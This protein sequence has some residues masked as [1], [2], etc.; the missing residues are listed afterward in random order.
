MY[1][2][3]WDI[4]VYGTVLLFLALN[5]WF[6]TRDLFL[7]NLIP[8]A[9]LLVLLAFVSMDR[10]LLLVVFFAPLSLSLKYLAGDMGV[11]LF[12]PTEPLLAGLMILFILKVFLERS[13]SKDIL[14]HPVTAVVILQLVWIAITSLTSSMPLV[15]FKFLVARLWFVAGFYFVAAEMFRDPSAMRKYIWAYILPFT[16]VILY[17]LYRQGQHGLMNQQ[18]SHST[19]H[20]FY[21]DH[22]AYGASMAFL[23]P[24]LAG[25]SF[26]RLKAGYR[27][28]SAAFLSLFLFAMIFS[29][30]R[31]A[32]LSMVVAGL[33]FLVIRLK[34]PVSVLVFSALVLAG[35]LFMYRT[36]IYMRLEENKQASS[37]DF[38]RH[39]KSI[40][41]ITS[42]ASNAER[43]NRWK[44]AWRMFRERP[45]FGW[46]PGT[47]QFKYAAFQMSREKTYIST[48][49]GDRG[50]A[51]SEYLGPL[52]ESGFPGMLIFIALA[53]AGISTGIRVY[54]RAREPGTKYFALSVLLG[55]VTY[56]T[57]GLLNNFLHTDKASA[58]FWGFLAMLVAMDIRLSGRGS[59]ENTAQ[60]NAS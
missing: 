35:F 21:N 7:F 24:V 25:F 58:L 57:H 54:R 9:G 51:H 55:L 1:R 12:L 32:W 8:V 22:T 26:T 30:T 41:N 40:S 37:T 59:S 11:D 50:N 14:Y 53:L 34:I 36:E 17:T 23:I 42:D 44:S 52:S 48:N 60:L 10:L 16:L 18:A 49:F 33:V 19:V 43:I 5:L 3:T 31:A 6:M 39:V 38:A 2:K 13:L 45:L 15:S 47:Y 56:F 20:P 46:G 4:L 28:I 27:L 29:Y